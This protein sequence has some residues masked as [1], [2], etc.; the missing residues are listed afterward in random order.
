MM[1]KA[2]AWITEGLAEDT[3]PIQ[4]KDEIKS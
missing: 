3:A 2:D 4:S 1:S